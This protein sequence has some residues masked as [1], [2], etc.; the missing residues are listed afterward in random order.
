LAVVTDTRPLTGRTHPAAATDERVSWLRRHGPTV[1]LFILFFGVYVSFSA[2]FIGLPIAKWR[3]E[4][5]FASDS[6]RVIRSLTGPATATD[7]KQTSVHPLFSILYSPPALGLTTLLGSYLASVPIIIALFGA[8]GVVFARVFFSSI[9]FERL[10]AFLLAAILGATSA[11]AFY[12]MIPETYAFTAASLIMLYSFLASSTRSTVAMLFLGV[13]AFGNLIT[14]I[15]QVAIVAFSSAPTHWSILHPRRL[16]RAASL[17]A[18]VLLISG[19]LALAQRQ[20]YP[21]SRPFFIPTYAAEERHYLLFNVDSPTELVQ[22][23]QN[24]LLHMFYYGVTAPALCIERAAPPVRSFPRLTFGSSDCPSPESFS[25]LSGVT[26]VMWS[27][28]LALALASLIGSRRWSAAR[29]WVAFS[30]GVSLLARFVL[31]LLYGDDLFLY[32]STWTF[33]IL[34]LAALAIRPVVYASNRHR[35]AFRAFAALFLVALSVH[36]WLFLQRIIGL[37]SNVRL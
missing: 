24:L 7:H 11:Q 3:G 13:V 31:H 2:R 19:F 37:Y 15:V 8:L 35:V 33:E 12:S 1:L 22:R 27:A 9:G 29:G 28:L 30:L 20:L 4:Y 10:D 18:A 14:S 16:L 5:L 23:T 36:S 26:V 32:T 21:A 34:A 25:P 6:A 17:V